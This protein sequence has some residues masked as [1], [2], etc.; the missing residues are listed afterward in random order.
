MMDES[1][2][3]D[4]IVETNEHLE[5]IEK[6][7]LKLSS[8]QG[9][10]ELLNEIFRSVHT[11]KGSSEYLGMISIAELSHRMENLL[12]RL[13]QKI[14]SIDEKVID[15]LIAGTDRIALL[16]E[17]LNT[18]GGEKNSIDDLL[19]RIEDIYNPGDIESKNEFNSGASVNKNEKV[20]N[21]DEDS[22]ILNS[23]VTY[24]EDYDTELFNIF[25]EQLHDGLKKL[26]SIAQKVIDGNDEK[27]RKEEC[28]DRISSLVNSANY[29]GY[30]ELS[31]LYDSWITEINDESQIIPQKL[32]DHISM[33]ITM[34]PKVENLKELIQEPLDYSV[35]ESKEHTEKII[36]DENLNSN[37]SP[38]NDSSDEKINDEQS[39]QEDG[40]SIIVLGEDAIIK[41]D[42][43]IN[44]ENNEHSVNIINEEEFINL[45]EEQIVA[46]GL[47]DDSL[48]QDFILETK[49]HLDEIENNLL[50]LSSDETDDIE[51]LN[52]IF[53]S[54]HTIKG[55]SEYLGI[56]KIAQLSH[57]VENL[58]DQIRNNIA[59][60]NEIIIDTLIAC[61]D[62]I[63]I[64]IQELSQSGAEISE[65]EDILHQIDILNQDYVAQDNQKIQDD[66]PNGDD[67]SQLRVDDK[68][69]TINAEINV[70]YEEDYDTELFEIFIEQLREGFLSLKEYLISISNGSSIDTILRECVKKIETFKTS[71][72]YM[73]YEHLG[74]TYERWI[75][76]LNELKNNM[77]A[78]NMLDDLSNILL[79]NIQ[80]IAAMFPKTN[81]FEDLLSDFLLQ[82]D[83]EKL[84]EKKSTNDDDEV[85][86]LVLKVDES[87][88]SDKPMQESI[89]ES[90]IEIKTDSEV[91][92]DKQSEE[93]EFD[94]LSFSEPLILEDF[95]PSSDVE[96]TAEIE[97]YNDVYDKEISVS[98]SEKD[99]ELIELSEIISED[100]FRDDL[101]NAQQTKELV[102]KLE[103]TFNSNFESDAE[104]LKNED[105]KSLDTTP[106]S[107]SDE[108]ILSDENLSKKDSVIDNEEDIVENKISENDEAK[109]DEKSELIN[110]VEINSLRD[111]QTESEGES[112]SISYSEEMLEN[113][114]NEFDISNV[115]KNHSFFKSETH[116]DPVTIDKTTENQIP[117]G[118]KNSS[119]EKG[120]RR[121]LSQSVRIDADKIDTL[122]NQVGELVV[123]R[124]FFSQLYNEMRS[125]EHYLKQNAII[126]KKDLK[127]IKGLTYRL[128]EATL[129]LGRVAN[130]LQDKV[131]RVRM[132]PISQLFNRYPRLVH[133][134][135]KG[136]D[137]KV[138]LEILGEDTELDRM[139]IEK[140]ADPLIHIIRNSIDHGIETTTERISKGK[141]AVGTL[142]LEAYHESNHVVIKIIDDGRGINLEKIKTKALEKQLLNRDEIERMS[143]RELTSLIM[144]PGF[145]TA[146][147]VT[148]TSG[149]GV[150]MDVVKK[151][152]EKLNG[153]LEI[154]SKFGIQTQ[155]RIKIPLTLAI[156]PALL[157]RIGHDLFTIPLSTVDETIRV[158]KHE[159]TNIEGIEVIHLRNENIPLLRLAEVFN[160]S[161]N[162]N[163]EK[164]FVVIV[165]TSSTRVG[166]VVDTLLGQ[167]EVVIKPLED[168]LQESTGFSGATILGDGRIS[169]ILDVYELVSLCKDKQARKNATNS[170]L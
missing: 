109:N 86:D 102:E 128:N 113:L 27:I 50:Q 163:T 125:F 5:E 34:F 168:Y 58:L 145:S 6:N 70:V 78:E 17:D 10:S 25:I 99:P 95:V 11:I 63:E 105:F 47:I 118:I 9:D 144:Q 46:G 48:L 119:I 134:L 161:S 96:H 3:Q 132:L 38:Q 79:N 42:K 151:N 139:V 146:S 1:L 111:E 153:T 67:F 138:K 7:L 148:H 82:S 59:T 51:I 130:E 150:G 166:L 159:L 24:E 107:T 45:D 32:M 117:S 154:E 43:P 54:I 74:S 44:H 127:Q 33:V 98:D 94:D 143:E 37:L 158:Y 15:T 16:I 29:M 56:A 157:V 57:R 61:R 116:L 93:E 162:N 149:R 164:D 112:V 68:K 129:A 80:N 120:S 77:N 41:N 81:A 84:E 141:P 72:N 73:G 12:D 23:T 36:N 155:I 147:Q 35:E 156:I 142:R 20:V 89:T 75:G 103:S 60:I 160:I 64:L 90:E 21:N 92:V 8:G 165:K 71:A 152:V 137:K 19:Q 133:D 101:D 62:R 140:I 170:V 39:E 115:D 26:R 97:Q 14:L 167:E 135:V 52:D 88:D 49:E 124:A 18:E 126:E 22:N 69:D 131:M 28:L 4:F 91:T 30:D 122:I 169:L 100:Y 85:L 65:I 2:L 114:R 123:S 121:Q 87:T 136:V 104:K 76:D 66:H 55:S 31:N 110:N 108:E 40:N 53:R 13:R 106:F 83:A